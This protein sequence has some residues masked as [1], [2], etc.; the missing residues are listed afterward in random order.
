LL[1]EERE[2]ISI[3]AKLCC[4]SLHIDFLGKKTHWAEHAA[5]K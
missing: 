2:L 4:T 1:R 3:D 5:T